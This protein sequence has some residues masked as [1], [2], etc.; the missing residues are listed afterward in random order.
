MRFPRHHRRRAQR[1]LRREL[2]KTLPAGATLDALTASA[3]PW[4]GC[5]APT[6]AAYPGLVRI[7]L[8][9]DR[10]AQVL[11]EAEPK[12]MGGGVRERL[13]V[14]P[15]RWH[16]PRHR[17]LRHRSLDEAY[18]AIVLY[19]HGTVT[20]LSWPGAVSTLLVERTAF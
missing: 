12:C 6:D 19:R 16:G 5:A 2:P 3:D 20:T 1:H 11:Y 7:S 14:E 15:V 13:V 17:E 10:L 18:R 4:Q 9:G 8:A